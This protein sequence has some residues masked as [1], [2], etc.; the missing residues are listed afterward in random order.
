MKHNIINLKHC[1]SILKNKTNANNL[2][3]QFKIRSHYLHEQ[4]VKI[5]EFISQIDNR[6]TIIK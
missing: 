3:K 2:K 4:N 6:M 1:V 5:S